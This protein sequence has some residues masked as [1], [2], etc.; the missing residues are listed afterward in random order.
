MRLRSGGE[1]AEGDCSHHEGIQPKS[2]LGFGCDMNS[3]HHRCSVFGCSATAG[4][5]DAAVEA[6]EGVLCFVVKSSSD[7]SWGSLHSN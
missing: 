6:V 5:G 2:H 3:S 4:A 7:S 1:P